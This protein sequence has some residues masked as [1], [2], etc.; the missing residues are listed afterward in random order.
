M[1]VIFHIDEKKDWKK[2]L[3]N[4]NNMLTYYNSQDEQIIIEILANGNAVTSLT[5]D[6]EIESRII[7]LLDNNVNVVACNNSINEQGLNRQNILERIYIVASGVVELV[8][9]QKQGFTYIKP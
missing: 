2:L 5:L 3:N 4:V 7:K 6:S 1:K 9:K 8:E